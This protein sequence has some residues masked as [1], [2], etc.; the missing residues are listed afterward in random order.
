MHALKCP[1]MFKLCGGAHS[2]SATVEDRRR[3]GLSLMKPPEAHDCTNLA[4]ISWAGPWP[5]SLHAARQMKEV[6]RSQVHEE[7]EGRVKVHAALSP[8]SIKQS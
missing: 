6:V 8:H 7:G 1:Y 4:A 2:D 3:R 5:C